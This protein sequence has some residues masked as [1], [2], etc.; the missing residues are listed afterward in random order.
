MGNMQNSRN[1]MSPEAKRR[2][3]TTDPVNPDRQSPVKQKE[4]WRSVLK[5]QAM[6]RAFFIFMCKYAANYKP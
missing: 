6:L 1:K 4:L 5:K 3:H 2:G